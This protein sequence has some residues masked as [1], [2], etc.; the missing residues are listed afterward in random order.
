[1]TAGLLVRPESV[2]D[3]AIDSDRPAKAHVGREGWRTDPNGPT[4]LCGARLRGIEVDV[5]WNDPRMCSECRTLSVLLRANHRSDPD[6][7]W[8]AHNDGHPVETRS[9]EK[10]DRT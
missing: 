9:D 6:N 5:G 2:E 10:A 8:P 4:A 7:A 3:D 1:M